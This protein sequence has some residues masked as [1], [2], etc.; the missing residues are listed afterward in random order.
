[1]WEN[2][3][4]TLPA[5][6]RADLGTLD[7][8]FYAIP[9]APKDYRGLGHLLSPLIQGPIREHRLRIQYS[10]G[11]VHEVDPYALIAYAAAST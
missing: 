2:F 5:F 4:K 6:E 7:R 10:T 9:Y 3:S 1:L 8:K 11:P